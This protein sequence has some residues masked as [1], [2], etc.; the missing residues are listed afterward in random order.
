MRRSDIKIINEGESPV[1]HFADDID[2]I[3]L[4]PTGSLEASYLNKR[5]EKEKQTNISHHSPERARR[6]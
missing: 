1:M 4:S 3:S 5:K 2:Q 6:R